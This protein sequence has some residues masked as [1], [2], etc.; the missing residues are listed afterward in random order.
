VIYPGAY[1]IL[2]D[3]FSFSGFI[4]MAENVLKERPDTIFVMACRIRTKEDKD[5]ENAFKGMAEERKLAKSFLFLNTVED[6]PS[7]MR[8]CAAVIMPASSPMAGVLEIPMVLLEAAYME[9]PVIYPSFEPFDE[10]TE[11]GIGSAVADMSADGYAKEVINVL[12]DKTAAGRMGKVS[13]EAVKKDFSFRKMVEAYG[14]LYAS[15][16]R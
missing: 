2:N 10:L 6:M 3:S 4:S 16:K 13:R 1:K 14:E 7:L 9:R 15:L 8:E 12:T 11:K 5:L